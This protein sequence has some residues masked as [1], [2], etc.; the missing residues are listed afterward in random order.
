MKEYENACFG[1]D[2]E[3]QQQERRDS[4]SMSPVIVLLR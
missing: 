3:L 1:A 4:F 2:G